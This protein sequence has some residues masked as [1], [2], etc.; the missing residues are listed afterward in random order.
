ML[1][2]KRRVLT[3]HMIDGRA[4]P[5]CWWSVL[6]CCWLALQETCV[7]LCGWRGEP[8]SSLRTA[9]SPWWWWD[10][11]LE[12]PPSGRLCRRGFPRA[13]TVGV[14]TAW[15]GLAWLGSAPLTLLSLAVVQPTSCSSAA[16]PSPKTSTSSP[17]GR[18]RRRRD[19]WASSL[20]SL[21][22]RSADAHLGTGSTIEAR[23]NWNYCVF[24]GVSDEFSTS[25]AS[26]WCSRRRRCTCST[27]SGT[28]ASCCGNSLPTKMPA[29]TLQGESRHWSHLQFWVPSRSVG[30]VTEDGS[31]FPRSNAKEMP[32]SVRGA[33]LEVFQQ[34]GALSAE[35]AEQMLL[36]METSGRLQSETWSW[37]SRHQETSSR[38]CLVQCKH[39]HTVTYLLNIQP[40]FF[41]LTRAKKSHCCHTR[42]TPPLRL[43]SRYHVK[44]S[45]RESFILICWCEEWKFRCKNVKLLRNNVIV[46]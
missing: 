14:Y 8:W 24:A 3:G 45:F 19:S 5:Q 42:K 13:D 2:F 15:P 44:Q 4:W 26:L 9:T 6:C 16:A 35:D 31:S 43:A 1:L 25:S 32:A 17:S 10:Q 28:P 20:P 39:L 7:C 38:L 46:W 33:L 18:R 37:S 36:A 30:C 41:L 27:G 12:W 40:H 11:E 21:G 29:F 22:T 23:V 34:E